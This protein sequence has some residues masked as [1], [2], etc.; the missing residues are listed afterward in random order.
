MARQTNP[1]RTL[2]RNAL[3]YV[4]SQINLS[5]ARNT[6]SEVM[7]DELVAEGV[8]DSANLT[9][10]KNNKIQ[11]AI[12]HNTKALKMYRWLVDTLSIP[13]PTAYTDTEVDAIDQD[14]RTFEDGQ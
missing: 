2:A 11:E 5:N 7:Y 6:D 10:F 9:S 12:D 4:T 1:A 14:I 13:I 8:F 3:N